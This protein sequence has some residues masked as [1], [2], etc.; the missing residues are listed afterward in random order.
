MARCGPARRITRFDNKMKSYTLVLRTFTGQEIVL[1]PGRN[2][3]S[4]DASQL[5][6]LESFK[7]MTVALKPPW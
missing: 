7:R 2:S 5:E 6:N 4:I 3:D 1:T